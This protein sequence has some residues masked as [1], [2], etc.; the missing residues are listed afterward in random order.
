M[1][2]DALGAAGWW[3]R[4][5]PTSPPAGT[6]RSRPRPMIGSFASTRAA[7]LFLT[8]RALARRK[9]HDGY[10]G[11]DL[12]PVEGTDA[13]GT[14]RGLRPLP[15]AGRGRR[16]QPVRSA[17]ALLLRPRL[18]RPARGWP[19]DGHF[20]GWHG[21]RSGDSVVRARGE[22]S[23]VQR[24]CRRAGVHDRAVPEAAV[25][26]R[27]R[28]TWRETAHMFATYTRG[29][30]VRTPGHGRHVVRL[31]SWVV[32]PSLAVWGVSW[33]ARSSLRAR[34]RTRGCPLR[35]ARRDRVP[36]VERWRIPAL[37][38]VKDLSG[39]SSA[40]EQGLIDASRGAP[41][42]RAREERLRKHPRTMPDS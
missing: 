40:Q 7:A 39:D 17:F 41:Q 33:P 16:R 36:V 9:R 10:R 31:L 3:S 25:R 5:V 15:Q 21:R 27:S 6:S 14:R 8:V 19:I 4:P 18:S 22:R 12:H 2:R 28:A 32:G 38:A 29:G 42:P 35:R 34:L 23:C 11:R 13:P 20:P 24:G 37:I 30:Y 26:W 1:E